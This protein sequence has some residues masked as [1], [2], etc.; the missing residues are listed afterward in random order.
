MESGL[1]ADLNGIWGDAGGDVYAVGNV[2][3]ILR[4][5]DGAWTRLPCRTTV[6]LRS[7]W[8]DGTGVVYS[9]V[10]P[11]SATTV[12]LER[13]AE[14]HR[15]QSQFHLG[16]FLGRH[17]HSWPTRENPSPRGLR[18]RAMSSG[19]G[20]PPQ[21]YLGN[22]PGR[23][24]HRPELRRDLRETRSL[25]GDSPRCRSQLDRIWGSSPNDIFVVG[26]SDGS[27]PQRHRLAA[28]E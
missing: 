5:R 4:Y 19:G 22:G 6:T 28:H 10:T 9:W 1:T 14:R 13:G 17:I 20:R 26:Q 11:S 3:S 27:A 24:L 8:G 25:A 18:V 12:F 7:V 2:G 23:V 21:R 15:I 16:S